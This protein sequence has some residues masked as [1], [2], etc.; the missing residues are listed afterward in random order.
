ML[1]D[2][3]LEPSTLLG[4]LVLADE[5]LEPSTLLGVLVLAD[6]S[7]GWYIARSLLY[8]YPAFDIFLE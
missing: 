2:E 1:A 4:V 7:L 6:E 3:S 5:S 8:L